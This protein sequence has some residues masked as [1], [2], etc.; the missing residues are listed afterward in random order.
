MGVMLSFILCPNTGLIWYI[1]AQKSSLDWWCHLLVGRYCWM[2]STTLSYLFILG[3]KRCMLS[4]LLVCGG[5]RCEFLVSKFI[6]P[7]KFVNVLKIAHKHPQACWN[8]YPLLSKGLDLG[9]WISSL[10][11]PLVQMVAIPFSPVLIIRQSTL[12]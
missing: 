2:R 11:C 4:C 6:S 5:Y 7:V 12:F 8:P 3:L 1:K 9:L 10:G